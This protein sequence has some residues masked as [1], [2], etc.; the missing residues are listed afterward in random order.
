M[1]YR[2]DPLEAEFRHIYGKPPSFLELEQFKKYRGAHRV[3]VNEEDIGKVRLSWREQKENAKKNAG[4]EPL[5]D[6]L[7]E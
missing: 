6:F 3:Y 2:P 5:D 7:I 4:I 1:T